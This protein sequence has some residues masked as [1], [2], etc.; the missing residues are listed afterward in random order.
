MSAIKAAGYK[1]GED[2]FIALDAASS[3]FY[4]KGKYHLEGEGKALRRR[5]TRRNTTPIS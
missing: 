5:G 1:P 3:E 2:V 4:K